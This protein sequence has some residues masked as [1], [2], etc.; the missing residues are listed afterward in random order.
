MAAIDAPGSFNTRSQNRMPSIS[1]S[2][3]AKNPSRSPRFQALIAR[4]TV[5][6]FC[7]DIAHEYL[8]PAF[9]RGAVAATS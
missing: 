8:A 2:A 7:S 4:L 1:G 5:S 6:T 9:L 3:P